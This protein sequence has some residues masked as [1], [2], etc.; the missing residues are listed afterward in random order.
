[1]FDDIINACPSD[2]TQS[3]IVAK[4]NKDT[5]VEVPEPSYVTFCKKNYK[6]FLKNLKVYENSGVKQKYHVIL[7]DSLNPIDVFLCNN[8]SDNDSV[9]LNI[10]ILFIK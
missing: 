8:K 9:I 7:K 6:K 10:Y 3:I 4:L 5:V 1:M 2:P